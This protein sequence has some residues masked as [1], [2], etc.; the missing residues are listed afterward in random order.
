MQTEVLV[1]VI[2]AT[3][4]LV[5]AGGSIWASLK[6]HADTANR[7]KERQVHRVREPLARAAFDLQSRIYNILEKSFLDEFYLRGDEREKNYAEYNTVF[8]I[9]QYFCWSEILRRDIQ[10]IDLGYDKGTRDLSNILD[11]ITRYWGTDS[12]P[13]LLRI[14]SGEQR[15]IGDALI[16]K[17]SAGL[18]C[19]GYGAFLKDIIGS[20]NPLIEA[21]REDVRSTSSDDGQARGRLGCIQRALVDLVDLLDPRFQRFPKNKRSKIEFRD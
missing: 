5:S 13:E 10:F 3:V 21:L 19:I 20:S 18:E 7:D 8:Q 1:A 4:A 2:A 11:K 6:I 14:F 17:N 16:I 15:A 9:A 12:E